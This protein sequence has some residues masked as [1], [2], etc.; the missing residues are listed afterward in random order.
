MKNNRLLVFSLIIFFLTPLC[1]NA[2]LE[3]WNSNI[4]TANT[5]LERG[6]EYYNLASY[7]YSIQD[8]ENA[9][10]YAERSIVELSIASNS[11]KNAINEAHNSRKDWLVLYTEHYS[12]KVQALINAANEIKKLRDYYYNGQEDEILMSIE[13]IRKYENEFKVSDTKMKD[14]KRDN[15]SEFQ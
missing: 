4:K 10:I 9:T 14:I 12:K 2:P 11:I 6:I 15:I 5:R 3:N 1:I 13:N 8:M 7:Y